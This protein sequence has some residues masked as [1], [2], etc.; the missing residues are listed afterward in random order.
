MSG[1][2]HWIQTYTGRAFW[3]LQPRAADV[4]IVD[5]AHA[6]GMLCRYNRMPKFFYSVAEHCCHVS[7]LVG[8]PFKLSGLMHDAP[9]AYSPFGDVARP[10][11][12]QLPIVKPVETAI[13]DAIVERYELPPEPLEVKCIDVNICVDEKLQLFGPPPLVDHSM[14]TD[15]PALGVII[16]GW[17]PERAKQEFL[18]R[19]EKLERLR[20]TPAYDV[21]A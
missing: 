3:P 6:L 12:I 14:P 13:W 1:D 4:N 17:S 9:E 19:F 10:A 7:D 16:E 21:V 15:L 2:K 8:E 11:K 20:T 5:I 18:R